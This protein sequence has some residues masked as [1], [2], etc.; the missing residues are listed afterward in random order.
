MCAMRLF[1]EAEEQIEANVQRND[2]IGRKNVDEDEDEDDGSNNVVWFGHQRVERDN[3]KARISDGRQ[4]SPIV[5]NVHKCLL[6]LGSG[7]P[8]AGRS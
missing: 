2:D 7:R 1:T 8:S 4:C 3:K 6:I 5:M